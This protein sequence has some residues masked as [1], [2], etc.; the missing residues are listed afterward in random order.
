MTQAEYRRRRRQLMGMME[1]GSIAILPAA[2]ER[3]RNRDVYHPYRQD[4]DFHYLTGFSEPDA[5]AVLIPG[6]KR[7]EY[8]LFCRERNAIQE[9]WEGERAGQQGAVDEYGA[10]DSFPVEDLDEILPR[11]LEQCDRV[12]YAMGCDPELDHRMSDWINRVRS[13]ARSGIHGPVEFFALDHYLHELRLYKSRS[14]Q[15]KMRQAARISAHAHARVMR[16]CR[17]GMTE[18]QLQAE[19]EHE[20]MRLGARF[21]AYPP[22]VGGGRNGC[23][24]HY[25]E[26]KDVLADGDLILI[27][28]GCEY[29]HYASDITRTFPVNGRFSKPQQ[30]LYELVLAAQQAAIAAV[31]PGAH[32]EEP[33]TAAVKVITRGLAKLGLLK[34]T[35]AQLIKKEAYKKFFVHRTGHWLGMDVHDVGDYKVDGEWRMLEPGMVLTVE[36]GLYIPAG[37]RG[38]ARKWWNIGIRIEDDVLVTRDGNEVL[39]RD[40]PK[41]VAEIEQLM[42]ENPA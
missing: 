32:W 39:S 27:D 31:R 30:Q 12:Y 19:F 29:D 9:M 24:L 15:K 4:S 1:K 28:A 20:C 36:P 16:N 22:I 37:T 25:T 35:P 38:V 3:K 23:V 13:R 6:R 33:H 40:L 41:S 18:Y 17:P 34:G 5:V 11:M 8:I 26:N 21:Q 10:D 7:G 2:P 14:E 42:Q